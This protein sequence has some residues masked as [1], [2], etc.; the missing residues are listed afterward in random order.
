MLFKS[1]ALP[2][3]VHFAQAK[4]PFDIIHND[5]WGIAPRFVGSVIDTMSHLLM[6]V[7]VFMFHLDL[8]LH[9]KAEVL[10]T[11]KGHYTLKK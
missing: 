4:G 1:H 2:F 8:F 7:H 6:I 11:F 10:P 5:V 3:P 9:N